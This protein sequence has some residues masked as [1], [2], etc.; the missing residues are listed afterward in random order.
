MDGGVRQQGYDFHRIGAR[1]PVSLLINTLYRAGMGSDEDDEEL[2]D[3]REPRTVCHLC[4]GVGE[5]AHPVLGVLGGVP[6]TVNA[7]RVCYLCEGDSA[8]PGLCPPL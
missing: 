7:G 8:L 5:I 1:L 6:R 3:Y 2:P 4:G